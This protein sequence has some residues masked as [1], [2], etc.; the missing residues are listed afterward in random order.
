MIWER[1]ADML[2]ALGFVFV[3]GWL[4]SSG[5]YSITNLWQAKA[6]LVNVE[7][8]IVP[9]LQTQ[10][11]QANCDKQK[12]AQLAAQGI[13]ADQSDSVAAPD[14]KDLSGCPTLAPVKPPPVEKILPK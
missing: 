10:V 4:S 8:T 9:R 3:A 13:A 11:A 12:Y 5:Y 7:Q 1:R 14:W 6:K 2:S